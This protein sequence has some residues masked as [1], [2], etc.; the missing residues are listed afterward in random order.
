MAGLVGTGS[1]EVVAVTT[2]NSAALW[3]DP[4][5][6]ASP[7]PVEVDT[8]AYASSPADVSVGLPV[9]LS[10]GP[11]LES[12]MGDE[13]DLVSS[14][15]PRSV[16]Y[17]LGPT[18]ATA[19]NVVLC[20]PGAYCTPLTQCR[21]ILDLL[22]RTCLAG[23]KLAQLSCGSRGSEAMVCC[24]PGGFSP[25]YMSTGAANAAP[26]VTTAPPAI[27]TPDP[28]PHKCGTPH[29]YNWRSRYAG[30]GSQPWVARI[31]FKKVE[32]GAMEYP[33]CGSIISERVI[34]TAAHCALAKTATHKLSA[35]RVGEYDADE[36]PD[37]STGFCA[38]PPQDIPVD[39]VVVHPSYERA[40]FRHD[41]ALLVLK[42]PIAFS[43]GAQPICISQN[44]V[45]VVGQRAKLVGWGLAAGQRAVPGQQQQL[46]LPVL[47]LETCAQV[48]E[49]VV[50]V[51]S[52]M[53]CVGGEDG[54]DACSGFGG[55]PLVTLDATGTRYYQIAM[56]SF[57]S[58]KCGVEG[59]P[60]VY[61][62]VDHYAEWI[63]ANMV[64]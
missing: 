11:E 6:S 8:A 4:A 39:H 22:D 45:G 61:T 5:S 36:D 18:A 13:G 7:D 24:P 33:C 46:D 62:R 14:K 37:C 17:T 9:G 28:L 44:V 47:P 3:S 57:G 16:P 49:R 41:V 1:P 10:A 12:D 19:S 20:A 34:L 43:L 59:V 48:Y 54:H 21:T 38:R 55:A 64:Q 56:V 42:A 50:P 29:L 40:S 35:V 53:L 63:R 26:V 25:I 2:P 60:S 32:T 15:I 31:G 23:D 58:T 51:T 52:D 27:T 30:V